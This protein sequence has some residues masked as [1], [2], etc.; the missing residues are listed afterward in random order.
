MSTKYRELPPEP[1]IL[2][3]STSEDQAEEIFSKLGVID[4]SGEANVMVYAQYD[5]TT[6]ED[7]TTYWD[8]TTYE[9]TTTTEDTTTTE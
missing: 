6:Y 7:T 4:D 1:V 5:T 8:S 3:I 9:E 2:R